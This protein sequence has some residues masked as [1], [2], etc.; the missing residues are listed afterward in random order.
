MP[1]D[2][3]IEAK[4]D[5]KKKQ[6]GDMGIDHPHHTSYEKGLKIKAEQDKKKKK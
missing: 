1:T 3:V 6:R 5:K 2:K 4:S